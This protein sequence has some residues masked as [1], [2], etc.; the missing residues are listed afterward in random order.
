MR[1]TVLQTS[2]SL[3]FLHKDGANHARDPEAAPKILLV[4]NTVRRKGKSLKRL[5]PV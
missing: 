5:S 1:R 2:F 4:V 3:Q